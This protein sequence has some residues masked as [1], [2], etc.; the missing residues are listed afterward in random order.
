MDWLGTS[1]GEAGIFP[2]STFVGR[3]ELLE[4]VR[5]RLRTGRGFAIATLNLD[6]V[7]KLRSDPDFR[8]AYSAHTH[9][10]ADGHP[11]VWLE[12]L[13]GRDAQRVTGADLVLPLAR[14]AAAE[15]CPVALV[16]STPPSLA[17]AADRLTRWVPG[18]RIAASVSPPD[19]FDPDSPEATEVI[20]AIRESGAG[21]CFL[22][23]GAPRQERFAA[24]A[25]AAVPETGFVSIGAGLDFISGHQMRAPRIVRAMAMEWAWRL[26]SDPFRLS[27]RYTRC[28]LALPPLAL[29]ALQRREPHR[30]NA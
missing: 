18:L 21:L 29:S 28:A 25:I 5:R 1:L 6:H 3:T 16:G 9:V 4:D 26:A 24:R 13:A 14:I 22:A 20:E 17:G 12:R 2:A 8:S 7:V 15:C 27:G 10:T 23:L 30:E 11:V 19:P